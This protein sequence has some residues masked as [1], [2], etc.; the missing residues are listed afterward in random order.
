MLWIRVSGQRL[1]SRVRGTV[2]LRTLVAD[3]AVTLWDGLMG[4]SDSWTRSYLLG[5]IVVNGDI[6]SCAGPWG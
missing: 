3:Q 6:L 1:V 2:C 4:G 5:W